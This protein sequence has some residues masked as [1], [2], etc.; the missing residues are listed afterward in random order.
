MASIPN[1]PSLSQRLKIGLGVDA[2]KRQ[3]PGQS[4]PAFWK[5]LEKRADAAAS[6]LN[7]KTGRIAV[8]NNGGDPHP[9]RPF[10]RTDHALA[11]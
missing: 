9:T 10:A 5:C 8:R 4:Q 3:N 11:A 6:C 7:R 1:Q 2:G